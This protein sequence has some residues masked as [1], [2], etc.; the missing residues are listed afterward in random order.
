[1]DHMSDYEL[2]AISSLT[3]ILSNQSFKQFDRD[4]K[5]EKNT[6]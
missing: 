3:R 5:F 6:L 4:G 2:M 1:M